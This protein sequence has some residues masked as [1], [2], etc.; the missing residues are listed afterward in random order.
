MYYMNLAE[1]QGFLVWF[2]TLTALIC[3]T[4]FRTNFGKTTKRISRT[5]RTNDC[6]KTSWKKCIKNQVQQLKIRWLPKYYPN[7]FTNGPPVFPNTTDPIPT[8]HNTMTQTS[9]TGTMTIQTETEEQATQDNTPPT[10]SDTT[11]H[12]RHTLTL[13]LTLNMTLNLTLKIKTSWQLKQL[14]SLITP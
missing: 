2:L 1:N 8:V 6:A 14:T 13:N 12:P 11:R 10:P 4:N 3:Y 7:M 9:T 5:N